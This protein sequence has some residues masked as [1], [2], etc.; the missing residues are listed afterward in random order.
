MAQSEHSRSVFRNNLRGE[1]A[2]S[3]HVRYITQ[4]QNV[5]GGGSAGKQVKR[6]EMDGLVEKHK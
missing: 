4:F 1:D 6:T 3:R 5:Y 2:Y